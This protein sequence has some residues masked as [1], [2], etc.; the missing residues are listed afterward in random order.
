MVRAL[1]KLKHLDCPICL[2]NMIP[3][4]INLSCSGLKQKKYK[5]KILVKKLTVRANIAMASTNHSRN[6]VN[7]FW[8]LFGVVLQVVLL[9]AGRQTDM[10]ICLFSVNFP[11][12]LLLAVPILVAPSPRPKKQRFT[13]TTNTGSNQKGLSVCVLDWFGTSFSVTTRGMGQRWRAGG[14]R[15]SSVTN[16]TRGKETKGR[17]PSKRKRK[18]VFD[19]E[20]RWEVW[21]T[22]GPHNLQTIEANYP[23]YLGHVVGAGVWSKGLALGRGCV[24]RPAGTAVDSR[25]W[26]LDLGSTFPSPLTCNLTSEWSHL[27]ENDRTP[28][29]S[30]WYSWNG[31]SH[32]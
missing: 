8:S 25:L 17:S 30:H 19:S 2:Q 5:R 15:E 7:L 32:K 20:T 18:K 4:K 13:E 23:G 6:T 21:T 24:S 14:W 28:R 10:F 1:G 12:P 26:A 3:G 27:S 9:G 22:C 29:E 11:P 31:T 16:Q